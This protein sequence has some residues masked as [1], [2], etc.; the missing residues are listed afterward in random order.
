MKFDGESTG[1]CP[2][3]SVVTTQFCD[4]SGESADVGHRES[5]YEI[6]TEISMSA[7]AVRDKGR[8]PD[9]PHEEGTIAIE[10]HRRNNQREKMGIE[11]TF[12][13]LTSMG[14][15]STVNEAPS[16]PALSPKEGE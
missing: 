6:H 13:K 5:R 8:F 2:I 11:P 9:R 4:G 14:A 10:S 15:G 1:Q 16:H 12:F 7:E 3:A